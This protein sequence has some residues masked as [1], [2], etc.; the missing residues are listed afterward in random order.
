MGKALEVIEELPSTTSR[1]S[2]KRPKRH[3]ATTAP[4]PPWSVSDRPAG[5][6]SSPVERF[7]PP[8]AF[9]SDA[10]R[11]ASVLFLPCED[12]TRR[13]APEPAGRHALHV[14]SH[15]IRHGESSAP[16]IWNH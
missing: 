13:L 11:A 2:A 9:P 5:R 14:L 1:P 16:D 3:T 12:D 4:A 10:S 6:N 15:A 8:D 7:G